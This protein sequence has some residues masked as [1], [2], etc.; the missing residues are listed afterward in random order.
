[1]V[2]ALS[3]KY[4]RKIF[5]TIQGKGGNVSTFLRE[6]ENLGLYKRDEQGY[7]TIELLYPLSKKIENQRT[8]ARLEADIVNTDESCQI[9]IVFFFNGESW[10][11]SGKV[12]TNM[13][14]GPIHLEN[15]VNSFCKGA[16]NVTIWAV[17][18]CSR[19]KKQ[20][21]AGVASEWSDGDDEIV[22]TVPVVST[23]GC[24]L[25]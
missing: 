24:A 9:L 8:F 25:G 4:Q 23:Y 12:V 22:G 14:A 10:I 16:E 1:M 5:F 20:V 15:K 7:E 6:Q 2:N 21:E 11:E 17:W 3:S 13:G 18:D 19:A